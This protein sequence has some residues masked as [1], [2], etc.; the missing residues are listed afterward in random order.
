MVCIH[1]CSYIWIRQGLCKPSNFNYS[2]FTEKCINI[3]YS[4]SYSRHRGFLESKIKHGCKQMPG[5]HGFICIFSYKLHQISHGPQVV[6]LVRTWRGRWSEPLRGHPFLGSPEGVTPLA[7]QVSD[8]L[9]LMIIHHLRKYKLISIYTYFKT[10]ETMIFFRLL[11]HL[12]SIKL[13]F[14]HINLTIVNCTNI[15]LLWFWWCLHPLVL[16]F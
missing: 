12:P 10:N 9:L 1:I 2:T 5:F 16:K 4:R 15:I 3:F 7:A 8:H 6:P 14:P 11:R 13:A